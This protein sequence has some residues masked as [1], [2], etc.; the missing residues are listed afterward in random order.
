MFY[1]I[2][3]AC[4]KSFHER[5]LL[6]CLDKLELEYEFVKVFPLIDNIEFQ[7]TRKDV[8]CFGSV[9]MSHL[10]KKYNW[11]P[12]SFYNENH[13]YQIYSQYYK[14]ELLNYDSIILN[15]DE[16]FD[17]PDDLFFVRPCLDSKLFT[18]TVFNMT[19]WE[20][21]VEEIKANYSHRLSEKIQVCRMKDI[22]REIR[23]WVVKGK[24]VTASQYKLGDRVVYK[25]TN[26]PMIIDYVTKMA[27]IYSPAEAFVMDVCLTDD[28]LKIVEINNLN[29]AGFYDCDI[30]K[31]LISLEENFN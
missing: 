28:G 29:C 4:F 18:G 11:Q 30:Q 5:Q 26:E 10:A 23:C 7:T 9:K 19:A 21:L 6:V 25:E 2:Q 14:D 8:M 17:F 16:K 13:D 1:L 3:E 31:L 24:V 27:A 20:N 12:G 15:V 22:F